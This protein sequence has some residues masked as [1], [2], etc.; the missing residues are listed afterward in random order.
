M[1]DQVERKSKFLEAISNSAIKHIQQLDEE[2][3]RE[4]RAE[5]QRTE[6]KI[7]LECHEKMDREVRKIR[8]GTDR[9]LAEYSDEKAVNVSKK[10]QYIELQVFKEAEKRILDFTKTEKYV[11][12][13][14]ASAEEMAKVINADDV[15]LFVREQDMSVSEDIKK[16]FGK[17][18][19]EVD[20]ENTLGGLK[21]VSNAKKLVADDTYG[22]RLLQQ[23]KWFSENSGLKI[24]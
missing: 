7:H 17:C 19:V 14:L 2:V 13:L 10:R 8:K 21:A 9:T 1:S 22:T 3:Q 23:K 6:D 4:A 18:S 5:M 15:V 16:A 20:S 24:V 12:L 11:H